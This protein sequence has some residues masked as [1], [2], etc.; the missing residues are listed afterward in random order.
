MDN[1]THTLTALVLARAGAQRLAPYATAALVV[2]ANVS[3]IDYLS[4][5]GS[6]ASYLEYRY[7]W[8]HSLAGAAVLGAG[9]AVGFWGIARRRRPQPRRLRNL[10]AVSLLGVLSHSFLDWTTASGAQLLW[11]VK[12]TR[13]ALDWLAFTDPWLLIILVLGLL[14]PALFRLVAEEIGARRSD[15]GLRRGAWTA[16]AACALL[17][18]GRAVLHR[19]AVAQLE[20][21]LYQ[22]RTPVRAAALPTP[23]NPLRWEGV[24]ETDTTYE[25][26]GLT[27]FQSRQGFEPATTFYKPS[28]SPALEAALSTPAARRFLSRARFPQAV[29]TPA[30]EGWRVELRELASGAEPFGSRNLLVQIELN[31][32][33]EVLTE[34]IRSGRRTEGL[35]P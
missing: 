33:L 17:V 34:K 18:A 32:E 15:A 5:L 29:I 9:V 3:D 13:Y 14:L 12:D 2:A 31:R 4:F 26:V 25:T 24:V 27:L 20:S 10:L 8:T 21:R 22:S 23:L 7:A 11:P 19:D 16:L 35:S 30:A 1:V 28:P 6:A